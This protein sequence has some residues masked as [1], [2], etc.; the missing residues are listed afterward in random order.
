MKL[1]QQGACFSICKKYR[2]TLER[3][4]NQ[5]LPTLL[6]IGLNPSIADH[7]LNDPTILRCLDLAEREG[8]GRLVMTNLFALRAT[9]PKKLFKAKDPIGPA[10]DWY[11]KNAITKAD[12]TLIAWGNHG[13][14]QRRNETVLHLLKKPYFLKQNKS[15]QPAHPLYL[16]KSLELKPFV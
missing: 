11:L 4:W 8:F 12:K 10:N 5:Q 13:I 9:D 7:Q 2:Y 16:K 15:G 3:C 14:Y 1:E 6:V